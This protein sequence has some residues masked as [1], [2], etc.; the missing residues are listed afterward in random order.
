MDKTIITNENESYNRLKNDV[1]EK[2]TRMLCAELESVRRYVIEE[3]SIFLG[4]DFLAKISES[5]SLKKECDKIRGE[6]RSREEYVKAQK[7]LTEATKAV[8]T[9][10]IPENEERE[11]NKR[12]NRA[13]SAITTLNVT[14][15]NKIKDKTERRITLEKELDSIVKQNENGF[16]T[17]ND[18]VISRVKRAV[19]ACV[20]GYAE[21]VKEINESFGVETDEIEMPFDEKIIRLDIPVFGKRNTETEDFEKSAD[22]DDNTDNINY[23]DSDDNNG[24]LN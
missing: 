19:A 16:K 24:V 2:Y 17:I 11:E 5:E 21:E 9:L 14:L 1:K 7:E 8:K 13:I 18:E 20:N 23:I 4:D 3:S 15:N 6:F 12:L 22:E 10:K